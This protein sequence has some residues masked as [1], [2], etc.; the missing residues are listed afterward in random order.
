LEEISTA[1]PIYSSRQTEGQLG[2][3]CSLP[4]LQQRSHSIGEATSR[5]Q[6]IRY[7]TWRM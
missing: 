6:R 7:A 1:A 3:V 4:L 5:I 2:D